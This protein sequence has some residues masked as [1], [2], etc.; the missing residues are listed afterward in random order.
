MVAS[1]Y[2]TGHCGILQYGNDTVEYSFGS[3]WAAENSPRN[4]LVLVLRSY[5]N[6][7]ALGICRR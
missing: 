1:G 5:E 6:L 7:R 2:P 3:L 4:F